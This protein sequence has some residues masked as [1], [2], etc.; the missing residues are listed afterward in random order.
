APGRAAAVIALTV[1]CSIASY[2]LVELPVREGRL[3]PWLTQRRTLAVAAV[4]VALVIVPAALVGQ[5]PISAPVQAAAGAVAPGL[6]PAAAADTDTV[7]VVGD[8]VPARLMPAL[9]PSAERRG[10]TLV[11]AVAGGCSPLAVHQRIS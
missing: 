8:S 2:H 6:V 7:V 4:S 10:I 9:A 5:T 11:S 3:T 1:A